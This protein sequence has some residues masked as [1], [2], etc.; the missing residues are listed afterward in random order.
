MHWKKNF[1]KKPENTYQKDLEVKQMALA[2]IVKWTQEQLT[3]KTPHE[4]IL[5]GIEERL[6]IGLTPNAFSNAGSSPSN[7]P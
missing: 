2:Y 6:K 1:K 4:E 7:T 5:A 3:A